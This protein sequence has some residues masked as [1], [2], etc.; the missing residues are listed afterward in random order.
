MRWYCGT[1]FMLEH[2]MLCNTVWSPTSRGL[3]DPSPKNIKV[4][5]YPDRAHLY[6]TI[7]TSQNLTFWFLLG[8]GIK[9]QPQEILLAILTWL[10]HWL[11]CFNIR[12]I[13]TW[14]IVNNIPNIT[15]L[16]I[17]T[18]RSV[19]RIITFCLTQCGLQRR[20]WEDRH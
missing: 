2:N 15:P 3:S 16:R 18:P 17:M 12:T 4:I 14:S 6:S 20:S 10:I 1:T 8:S 13:C 19:K 7:L 11:D 9:E 5:F